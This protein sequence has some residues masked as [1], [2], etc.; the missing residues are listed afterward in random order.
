MLPQRH[1]IVGRSRFA[2]ALIVMLALVGC[3]GVTRPAEPQA[4]MLQ[5]RQE[6]ATHD[7]AEMRQLF[8]DFLRLRKAEYDEYAAGRQAKPP[9]IDILV[10]SGGG[11]WGA[12]G[13]GFLKG[14]GAVP[15]SEP[16]ARPKFDVVTGVS[17]GALIA[18][19]AFLGDEESID[20]VE[21][22]YR[23][24]QPDWVEE[25]GILYFLPHHISFAEVPGL[26]REVRKNMPREMI[27]R[28]AAE[29]D[30]RIL[31]VNTTNLDDASPR[32]FV[33]V[34][35]ARQAVDS[36]DFDRFYNIILAS[37]GIPGVFPY[38]E[39]DGQMYVDGGVTSNIIYGGRLGEGDSLPAVWQK[40]YPSVPNP[41]IRYWVIFNNQ[42]HALPEVVRARWPDI[43]TR[44]MELATRS[45]TI[46]AMRQLLA[47]SEI[48][49]LKRN[50]DVEVRIVAIPDD[51]TP[52]VPGTFVKETMNNLADLG[53]KMGADPAS[54]HTE[55]PSP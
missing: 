53:E 3:G 52:P 16:M 13:A 17:T 10:I 38:R 40:L 2:V 44:S 48:A 24:P 55:L 9:V 35:E 22:L 41:E 26:E 20:R 14:W 23:N 45:A 36:G 27:A 37:A 54:W 18:P 21:H 51:W 47:M 49:R 39:I 31:T 4:Q 50:A 11:D 42:L 15:K 19:F 28:L 6:T 43:I 12:F 5:I 29:G 25:R 33:L 7:L 32:A 8:K 30:D 34:D 46:T 1:S